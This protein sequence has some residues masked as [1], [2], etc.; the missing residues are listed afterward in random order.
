MNISAPAAS[1]RW[2]IPLM[3]VEVVIRRR[4]SAADASPFIVHVTLLEADEV[5]VKD[6]LRA[7]AQGRSSNI[8][9]ALA[10]YPAASAWLISTELARHYRSGGG[11]SSVTSQIYPHI[12]AA[13]AT[14][15]IDQ[16][17][18]Q[19]LVTAFRRV[20]RR[21]GLVLPPRKTN[22]LADSYVCQAG[23]ARSQLPALM[24]AFLKAEA[25]FGSPPDEDTQRL[26]MWQV[27]STQTYAFG[28]SRLHNIM[29]WDESAFHAGCF[30]RARRGDV[31]WP[32]AQDMATAIAAI[33]AQG[34]SGGRSIE[35]RA[36]IALVDSIPAIVAPDSE[37]IEVRI[38]TRT[39]TIA[40][41]RWWELP[42]PWP[43]R[44]YTST[45]GGSDKAGIDLPFLPTFESIAVF[46]ADSGVLLGCLSSDG[47]S[48]SVDAREVALASRKEITVGGETSLQVSNQ[49]HILFAS[50]GERLNVS[51]GGTSYQL[52]PPTRPNF[53]FDAV[54]IASGP[55]GGLFTH[56]GIL[57]IRFPGGMPEKA[58]LCISH[59]ALIDQIS[60]ELEEG[61]SAIDLGE[62]LPRAGPVGQL[63]MAITLGKGGR[64]L[65]RSSQW[66]WPG[67]AGLDGFAFDGPIPSNLVADQSENAAI[68]ERRIGL[69]ASTPWRHA[70]IAFSE[71]NRI[72]AFVLSRPGRSV[73]IVDEY[74]RERAHPPGARITVLPDSTERLV[75]RTDD[76]AAKLI[77]RGRTEETSFGSSGV[78]RLELAALAQSGSDNRIVYLPAGDQRKAETIVEL[79]LSTEPVNFTVER[80]ARDRCLKFRAH[81]NVLIDAVRLT[82]EGLNGEQTCQWIA[83]LGRRPADGNHSPKF[84]GSVEYSGGETPMSEL[85]LVIDEQL[86][87][88]CHVGEL[89]VRIEGEERYR[90]LRNMRGDAFLFLTDGKPWLP[91]PAA[92]L[93][94]SDLLARCVAPETWDLVKPI[95]PAWL[96]AG[97][98][99]VDRGRTD[100]L[101][102][103]WGRPLPAGQ[104]ST[105]VPLRHPVEIASDLLSLEPIHFHA[106]GA[107]G[108]GTEELQQL[109]RLASSERVRD[110]SEALLVDPLFFLGFANW[111]DADRTSARLRDFSFSR[112]ISTRKLMAPPRGSPSL[113][114]PSEGRLSDWHHEW[115]VD[116]F[117]DRFQLAMPDVP[118]NKSNHERMLRLNRMISAMARDHKA[119]AV[120]V[121]D[122]LGDRCQLA[123]GVAPFLSAAAKAWRYNIF[124]AFLSDVSHRAA[125]A[126]QTILEDIGLLLRLAPELA[127]FYLLLWELVRM[128]ERQGA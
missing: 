91:S 119:E 64:T 108:D 88:T 35:V 94:A 69:D 128:T 25:S 2:H 42:A 33:E 121:S 32:L 126:R 15:P 55:G 73:S 43:A 109:Y 58:T 3:S 71:S 5:K 51:V 87:D 39:R 127:A 59:P 102:R 27:R 118:D 72:V 38:G 65:V 9:K 28:L 105:W 78:R 20:A 74:G 83:P 61:S 82:L 31:A 101:L 57:H 29:V 97:K 85:T 4:L 63:S 67:L 13:F 111:Q 7:F 96:E 113:W 24:Q 125:T 98:A 112:L 52:T 106:F 75:I 54:R 123:Y 93:A 115:C 49:A 104:A 89:S 22:F 11:D 62:L 81:F 92:Y 76:P 40:A 48:L 70:G 6:G 80:S 30:A 122:L 37:S 116:R 56:P 114:R 86:T 12:A 19:E 44:I 45:P 53:A 120:P 90:D 84:W 10:K 99:L 50:L 8:A 17:Q 47:A 36:R 23:A 41:G 26:N 79:A 117:I 66:V 46:D 21:F 124:P 95:V 103:G 68:G 16:A 110:A 14:G 60:L 107:E 100:T 77:I 18:R 1:P 34:G